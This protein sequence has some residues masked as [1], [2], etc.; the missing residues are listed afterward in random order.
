MSFEDLEEE[1]FGGDDSMLASSCL[2]DALSTSQPFQVLAPT[3]HPYSLTFHHKVVVFDSILPQAPQAVQVPPP[4]PPQLQQ[5]P[6]V[7]P[8]DNLLAQ[9]GPSAASE[10]HA[11][12]VAWEGIVAEQRLAEQLNLLAARGNKTPAAAA[13]A[14]A[15]RSRAASTT[16]PAAA[17]AAAGRMKLECVRRVDEVQGVHRRAKEREMAAAR[18]VAPLIEAAHGWHGG[19]TNDDDDDDGGATSRKSSS[20]SGPNLRSSFSFR[21]HSSRGTG[22]GASS[23]SSSSSS[24][25]AN[26]GENA[27]T[28]LR[29]LFGGVAQGE[30]R[31]ERDELQ[32]KAA[33]GAASHSRAERVDLLGNYLQ[34]ITI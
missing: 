19:S 27:S 30:P 5:P 21:Y 29:M 18:V 31:G 23:S 4:L 7:D 9:L 32:L 16:T 17:A 1:F 2:L 13:A 25:S 12:A 8:N 6:V 15:P 11:A 24:S 10:W 33:F 26:S 34:A 14:G 22:S 3:S 28:P 20:S